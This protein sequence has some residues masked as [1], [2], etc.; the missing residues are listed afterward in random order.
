MI[1]SEVLR[2]LAEIEAARARQAQREREEAG[3]RYRVTC[4]PR[5]YGTYRDRRR[6]SSM[7]MKAV[8]RHPGEPVSITTEREGHEKKAG[9]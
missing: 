5:D 6:A 4:G 9:A 8:E 2:I 1:Y 7:A 3:D